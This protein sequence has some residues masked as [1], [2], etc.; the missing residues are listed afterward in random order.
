[1][2]SRPHPEQGFRS[3]LGIIRL[4]KPY[5]VERVEAAA[6]RAL[7]IGAPSY[8]SVKNIL[9][10]N[11]DRKPPLIPTTPLPPI[12]HGNLRGPDY[13]STEKGDLHPC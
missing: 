13:Y 7:D 5:G 8:T 12:R 9:K 4:E 10:N 11:L 6:R 1:M 2:A 3:C